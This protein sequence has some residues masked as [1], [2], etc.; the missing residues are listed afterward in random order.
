M[1]FEFSL[2]FTMAALA[3][4]TFRPQFAFEL[5]D[6]IS[7][8]VKPLKE[9]KAWEDLLMFKKGGGSAPSPDPNIGIAALKQAE[10][11]E[12][13]LK[14]AKEQFAVANKRQTEQDKIANQVTKQQL[15]AS[16]QA[17]GWA[18]EDRER[19]KTVFQPMQD[20]FIDTAK[21]WDSAERQ[22]KLAA[23]AKA[24]VM[25]NA[26]QQRQAT[27]RQQAAMGVSPTSGRFAGVDRAGEQA[28]ALTAAGAQN[29]SRNQVRKEGVA[30]RADAV[31][32]GNGLA[33]NPASSLGL[34]VS[35]GSAAMG[36]TSANNA[37]AAGNSAIL[38]NGYNTAMNGYAN[39]A[40]ILNQQY[41]NQLNAWNA[42]QQAS[43]S[44]TGGLFSGLGS[45]AGMG[46]M[47]Y[48]MSSK[49]VKEDKA[50]VDGALDAVESM[51]VEEWKYKDGVADG[52]RHIGPYAEDFQRATGKGDGKSIPVVDAVG[53]TMKAVQELS[54]KVDK[55]AAG[56]SIKRPERRDS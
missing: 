1:Q 28:T 10:L 39:Q 14:I 7:D 24:D 30:M 20:E 18:T 4:L 34:G 6:F 49:D 47:A 51:P 21:N 44:A 27:Q 13:W 55:I 12:D 22:N 19:Y 25:T 43:A 8:Q 36:T 33:V 32:M 17:Q 53:V 41:G 26:A 46:T 54:A 16:K 3:L 40:S 42:Q 31:N 2:L 52:G 29:M 23:E 56:R 38:Q 35:S 37:Q 50:P 5:A 11:G 48:M 45:L 9:R 15:D